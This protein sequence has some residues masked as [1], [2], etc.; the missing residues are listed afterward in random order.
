LKRSLT[1]G[2]TNNEPVLREKACRYEA[3]DLIIRLHT[4]VRLAC[5]LTGRKESKQRQQ[6]AFLM[7]LCQKLTKLLLE[8][9]F[10]SSHPS[11]TDSKI[12]DPFI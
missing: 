11:V 8:S 2:G 5:L 10:R 4:I 12:L 6:T 3:V 7:Y 9:S 1:L